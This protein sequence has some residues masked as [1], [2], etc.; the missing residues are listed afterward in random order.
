MGFHEQIMLL[1]VK[2]CGA[3]VLPYRA[4]RLDRMPAN[5]ACFGLHGHNRREQAR[6]AMRR[7]SLAVGGFSWQLSCGHLWVVAFVDRLCRVL[8]L[9]PV[10]S[11]RL[12]PGLERQFGGRQRAFWGSQP[13][14]CGKGASS[15]IAEGIR[16]RNG[17]CA[18]YFTPM[19]HGP[20]QV[21]AQGSQPL[22]RETLDGR[23]LS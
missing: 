23:W 12:R 19:G 3:E 14:N 16:S 13:T 5:H 10:W 9:Y 15:T 4:S 8:S 2:Q 6:A 7:T 17:G 21:V 11:V 18:G 22:R 1:A 20:H